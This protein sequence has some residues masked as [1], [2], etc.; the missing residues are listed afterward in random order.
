MALAENGAAVMI[1][2]QDLDEI[3]VLADRIAVIAGGLVSES[4]LTRDATVESIG[5]LMG[6][7]Q[8]PTPQQEM[9]VA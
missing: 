5:R 1:I 3:F 8:A 2:S 7:T 6:G 4:V 9:A